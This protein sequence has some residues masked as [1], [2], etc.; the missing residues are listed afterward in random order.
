MM[1][2]E[3]MIH[4]FPDERERNRKLQRGRERQR[5]INHPSLISMTKS[6]AV[7]GWVSPKTKPQSRLTLLMPGNN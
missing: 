5:L 6:A 1:K 2:A 4:R 7:W 3:Q